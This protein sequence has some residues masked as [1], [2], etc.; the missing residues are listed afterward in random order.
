MVKVV[1][2]VLFNSGA[3]KVYELMQDQE[4]G[5]TLEGAQK[6]VRH[7]Q[8]DLVNAVYKNGSNGYISVVSEGENISINIQQTSEIGFKIVEV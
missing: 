5:F 1:V 2:R 8:E 6:G 4:E 3:E 7:L